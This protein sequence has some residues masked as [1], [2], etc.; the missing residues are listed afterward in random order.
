MISDK[1][2]SQYDSSY[3]KSSSPLLGILLCI[4]HH[5]SILYVLESFIKSQWTS[6]AITAGPSPPHFI[7]ER[8]EPER[9]RLSQDY[10]TSNDGARIWGFLAQEPSLF[11]YLTTY[12]WVYEECVPLDINFWNNKG[13][14]G[15]NRFCCIVMA[16]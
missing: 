2:S 4:K 15:N 14:G 12:E 5:L 11:A 8:T 7:D 9:S 3:N 16:D 6:T 13:L 1:G 10:A